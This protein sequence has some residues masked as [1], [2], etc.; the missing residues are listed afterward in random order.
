MAAGKNT[1]SKKSSDHGGAGY[2]GPGLKRAQ[3]LLDDLDDY[4]NF[5][6]RKS[7]LSP[8]FPRVRYEPKW[9]WGPDGAKSSSPNHESTA[10]NNEAVRATLHGTREQFNHAANVLLTAYYPRELAYGE[11]AVGI[12]ASEL[13]T[14]DNHTHQHLVGVSMGRIAAVVSQHTD[15]LEK[16]AQL[17]RSWSVMLQVLATPAP[18]Y[19]VGSAGYRSPHKPYWYYATAWL[20]QLMGQP[21]PLP[22]FERKPERWLDPAAACVR[23]IRYLQQ[24]RPE[25]IK[26]HGVDSL[27]AADVP[28]DVNHFSG[29]L[30]E[31]K[32]TILV[33]RK[34]GDRHLVV[35]P[36]PTQA[37]DKIPRDVCDWV[38]VPHGISNFKKTMQAMK[39]GLNWETPVPDPPKGAREFEFPTAW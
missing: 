1:K 32:T 4:D 14:P 21:G 19:Y 7:S 22:E 13:I 16:S 24:I 27:A 33:Y 35:I 11:R 30:P 38:E 2:S 31:M 17:I 5:H 20:R 28:V 3:S 37:N 39:F 25:I 18:Y 10:W 9:A 34:E 8:L 6:V 36:K 29:L 15:L 26:K 23:G 12:G